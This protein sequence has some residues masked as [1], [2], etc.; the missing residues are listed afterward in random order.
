MHKITIVQ[1]Y[2]PKFHGFVAVCNAT[3]VHNANGIIALIHDTNI[4]KDYSSYSEIPSI[5]CTN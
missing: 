1:S 3:S 5:V 4:G 2:T